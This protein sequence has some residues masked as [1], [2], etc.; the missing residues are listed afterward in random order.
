MWVAPINESGDEHNWADPARAILDG[1]ILM[2]IPGDW[3]KGEMIFAGAQPGVD[4]SVTS[5]PGSEG[6]F[7]FGV[8][9]F[10]IH[11]NAAYPAMA[12]SF[13]ELILGDAAQIAFSEKK[14]S[15]PAVTI[16][17]PATK[18]TDPSLL[19]SYSDLESARSMGRFFLA[20]EWV[21]AHGDWV[22]LA[23]PK[24]YVVPGTA[25]VAVPLPESLEPYRGASLG[26]VSALFKCAYDNPSLTETQCQEQV[27]PTA[28]CQS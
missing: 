2:Y 21:A 27:L 10:T 8:D 5:A 9:V 19:A 1:T 11:Q 12:A 7:V 23:I 6:T 17:D 3:A 25:G 20:P 13:V 16:D 28:I 26:C 24:D 14:G 22:N 18:I 15:T 4:F